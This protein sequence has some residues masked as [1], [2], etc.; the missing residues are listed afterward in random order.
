VVCV[1]PDATVEQRE[2]ILRHTP[3]VLGMDILL[4]K[5]KIYVDEQKVEL[6]LN[7]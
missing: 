2:K 6:T 3:S 5:F 7:Q 1:P 4:A